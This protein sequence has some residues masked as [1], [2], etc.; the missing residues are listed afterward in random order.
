MILLASSSAGLD[1]RDEVSGYQIW[2]AAVAINAMCIKHG[3]GGLW[4][5]LGN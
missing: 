5:G 3:K 1:V 2:E 4:K